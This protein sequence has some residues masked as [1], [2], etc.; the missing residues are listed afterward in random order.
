MRSKPTKIGGP[1]RFQVHVSQPVNR[2]ARSSTIHVKRVPFRRCQEAN[3]QKC[4]SNKKNRKSW[5]A[6]KRHIPV[7]KSGNQHTLKKSSPDVP[8][9]TA[10]AGA[11][12]T[13][14]LVSVTGADGGGGPGGCAW[15][16]GCDG[17]GG[18]GCDIGESLLRTFLAVVAPAIV[19]DEE[20]G[21]GVG[22]EET[23]VGGGCW[24]GGGG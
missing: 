13:G 4:H 18:A 20:M 9:D 1:S 15:T 14:G 10:V 12:D 23:G 11:A 21:I 19:E 7:N 16:G 24:S 3:A 6:Q 17:G 22:A 5:S 8:G 2:Y